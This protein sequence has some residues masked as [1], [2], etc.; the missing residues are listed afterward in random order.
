MKVQLTDL[1][2]SWDQDFKN[3]NSL[4][5]KEFV[6]AEWGYPYPSAGDQVDLSWIN[7]DL[8]MNNFIRTFSSRKMK[9]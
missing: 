4:H 8:R 1:F 2:M 3:R 7:Q 9:L 5:R 6:Y